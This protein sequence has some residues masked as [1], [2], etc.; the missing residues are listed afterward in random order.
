MS[1]LVGGLRW[2]PDAC[3]ECGCDVLSWRD[4]GTDAAG[5]VLCLSCLD[6]AM[7]ETGPER[8]RCCGR[9]TSADRMTE[10][11]YGLRQCASCRDDKSRKPGWIAR[12]G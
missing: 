9:Y 2:I 11:E 5:R 10:T 12:Y 3:E 8:C 4:G 7:R 6:D 1:D